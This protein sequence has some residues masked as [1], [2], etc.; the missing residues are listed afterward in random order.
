MKPKETRKVVYLV[1]FSFAAFYILLSN[2]K[3]IK[4]GLDTITHQGLTSYILAYLIIGI[5][6]FAATILLDRRSRF[7]ENLGLSSSIITAVWISLLFTLPMFLGGLFFFKFNHQIKVENLI[8]GTIVAGFMEELY[9]RGFLFGQLFRRTILG[10][11][12]SVLPGAFIFALGHLNQSQNLSELAGIFLITFSGAVFFAWLYVEWNYNLWVPVLIHTFMNLAWS[13][14]EVDTT[15]LGD[16]KANIFRGLTIATAI[17][18]TILFKRHN[19]QKLRV[20]GQTILLSK[21]NPG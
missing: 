3:V 7:F 13:L 2:F 15:A 12:L 21:Q 1:L 14:F 18:F 19:G 17:V 11:I 20:N 9:F 8:A 5:P 6:L 4:T 16:V 10:F